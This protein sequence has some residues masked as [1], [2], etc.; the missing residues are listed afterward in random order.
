MK[1]LIQTLRLVDSPESIA[2][3]RKAHDEIWPE[4]TAGIRSVGISRM[5]LYLDG[6]TAVMLVE[7]PDDLDIEAAFARLAT[8]PRQQEWEEHV[9]RWQRCAP[10]STSAGKWTPMQQIFRLP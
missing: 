3:Y 10:G 6:A 7:Y 1:T 4:I 5:D 9:A 8:L 2:A